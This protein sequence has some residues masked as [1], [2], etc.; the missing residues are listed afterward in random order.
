MPKFPVE[1]LKSKTRRPRKLRVFIFHTSAHAEIK[2]CSTCQR[3]LN[4]DE[5]A[6]VVKIIFAAF[7]YDAHKIISFGALIADDFMDFP[8]N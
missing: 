8:R 2:A 3:Q 6:V 7:I 1:A 4:E 5:G